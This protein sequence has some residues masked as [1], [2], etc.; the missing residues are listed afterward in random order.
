VIAGGRP[1][2]YDPDLV[3]DPVSA[4]L[5]RPGTAQPSV[6]RAALIPLSITTCFL[7]YYGVGVPFWAVLLA[8]LPFMIG[9]SAA[10]KW[11]GAST[12]AFDRDALGL[13]AGK[14]YEALRTRYGRALGMR[15][16]GPPAIA[17]ERRGMIALESG[18]SASARASYQKAIDAYD[19]GEPPVSVQ[20]GYAHACFALGDD[21]EAIRVYREVIAR[22][23]SLP[24][25][26]ENLDRALARAKKS[27]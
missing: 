27:A 15:L 3:G 10:P 18:D 23:G 13:L 22:A 6:V 24:K 2:P 11:A 9:F 8:S 21:D 16:F 19:D 25:V 14:K 7:L 4:R 17:A 1:D 26:Q 12:R 5:K 20:L